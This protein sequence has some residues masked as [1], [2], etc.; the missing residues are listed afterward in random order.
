MKNTSKN[1]K[2]HNSIEVIIA[3]VLSSTQSWDFTIDDCDYIRRQIDE[4]QNPNPNV[5]L[6]YLL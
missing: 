4:K 5:G 3:D 6:V 1:S 2:E